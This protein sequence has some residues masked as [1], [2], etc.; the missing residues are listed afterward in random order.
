[1][2]DVCAYV[3]VD[4]ARL[5]LTQEDTLL[6]RSTKLRCQLLLATCAVF[7]QKLLH[8]SSYTSG[9]RQHCMSTLLQELRHNGAQSPA[10]AMLVEPLLP[11]AWRKELDRQK[12][13]KG[14]VDTDLYALNI[15]EQDI[16][17]ACEEEGSPI[18]GDFVICEGPEMAKLSLKV[19]KIS[20]A[21]D[22]VPVSKRDCVE[23]V[24][25][26]A[27]GQGLD[28]LLECFSPFEDKYANSKYHEAWLCAFKQAI[29]GDHSAEQDPEEHL[30]HDSQKSAE[31][32]TAT[33]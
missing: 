33:G 21:L 31:Q 23:H 27:I 30:L 10:L 17:Q 29:S 25:A 3:H 2:Y 4:K 8:R 1:M 22:L 20:D 11:K 13:L 7:A 24:V 18:G 28:R 9:Y 12:T 26:N 5:K 16:A 6:Q 14:D 15:A 32:S 19:Q